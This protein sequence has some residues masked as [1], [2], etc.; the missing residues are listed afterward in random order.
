MDDIIIIDKPS[1]MT[2]HDVVAI[3]RRR[4]NIKKIGH[5][6]TLDPMATGVLVLVMN[7]ATKLSASFS[8]DDKEYI[9]LM[10]LGVVTDTQDASGEVINS[11]STEN[12]NKVT[13]EDVILSFLGKQEQIP[14]MMSAKHYNGK[15]L[16][17][18]ARK[19][20]V[21]DRDPIAIEIKDIQILNIKDDEAEFKV[22]CSKGT[23]IRTLCH[24][25]GIRLGCGAHMKALRRT[26]SGKFHIKDA[27]LLED[28]L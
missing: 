11:N 8:A 23:Y 9:C 17:M 5:C 7:K 14:P 25:I 1:G 27:M 19:G 22:V 10:K 2:S 20:I 4:L 12:I 26:R 13:L 18:L 16:Y 15:R 6:G 28:I 21:V 3:A 24:D